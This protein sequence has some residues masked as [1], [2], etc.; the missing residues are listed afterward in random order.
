MRPFAGRCGRHFSARD[1]TRG[2]TTSTTR[3]K[4]ASRFY[5]QRERFK[6]GTNSE[7]E[8]ALLWSRLPG[9]GPFSA[10][11]CLYLFVSNKPNLILSA[12]NFRLR[13]IIL[14]SLFL[15]QS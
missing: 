4:V 13:E 11:F 6:L 8:G 12:F 10:Q 3:N 1:Q 9:F 7:K 2:G 14:T 5:V 15:S